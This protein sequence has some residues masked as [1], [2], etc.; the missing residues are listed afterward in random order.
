MP[1]E[2]L[3]GL[4]SHGW[5]RPH[6]LHDHDTAL[7]WGHLALFALRSCPFPWTVGLKAPCGRWDNSRSP[8][9]GR[10]RGRLSRKK[11]LAFWRLA[12]DTSSCRIPFLSGA[13]LLAWPW[14]YHNWA[15]GKR[16]GILGVVVIEWEM[17]SSSTPPPFSLGDWSVIEMEKREPPS[18]LFVQE[19]KWKGWCWAGDT[20]WTGNTEQKAWGW[21][22][23]WSSPFKASV[24]GGIKQHGAVLTHPI[25][26]LFSWWLF[27]EQKLIN[28]RLDYLELWDRRLVLK[29]SSSR[30]VLMALVTG[31]Y[32]HQVSH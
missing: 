4:H 8:K 12:L 16:Y 30:L 5:G 20:S 26:L 19:V 24:L 21:G 7:A 22:G 23:L 27:T 29:M 10:A 1:A 6:S 9:R 31:F 25:S 13:S 17:I 3:W 18:L 28:V 2:Q 14:L 32:R 11:P 15:A